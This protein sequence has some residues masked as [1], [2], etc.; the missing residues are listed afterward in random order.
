VARA[1]GA[2]E[3]WLEGRRHRIDGPAVEFPNGDYR[4]YRDDV[5]HRDGGPAV[6]CQGV[7]E[8]R[9]DG[10]LHRDDGPAYESG[11]EKLWLRKGKPHRLGGPAV[12][13]SSGRNE[14]WIEGKRAVA[15]FLENW[16]AISGAIHFA[17]V[18]K[19]VEN[20]NVYEEAAVKS[21][22][23]IGFHSLLA[24]L[25]KSGVSTWDD[26]ARAA[27][28]GLRNM[29]RP[30]TVVHSFN[31]MTLRCLGLG[32]EIAAGN[33]AG[34]PEGVRAELLGLLDRLLDDASP[35]LVADP[36]HGIEKP[37]PRRD[38]KGAVRVMLTQGKMRTRIREDVGSP[39]AEFAHGW[40]QGGARGRRVYASGTV[41]LDR[42]DAAEA[43][44]FATLA[45]P[46]GGAFDLRRIDGATFRPVF[47]PGGWT[48]A[49]EDEFRAAAADGGAWRDNP[50]LE[51]PKGTNCALGVRDVAMAP[52]KT[53]EGDNAAQA[54]SETACLARAGRLVVVDGVVHRR[55]AEPVLEIVATE[56]KPDEA[57]AGSLTR[58]QLAWRLGSDLSMTD[59]Q[60]TFRLGTDRVR[61]TGRKPGF[62]AVSAV[63][64]EHAQ[65]L[66]FPP[67]GHQRAAKI[68]ALWEDEPQGGLRGW[69]EED[70]LP[71]AVIVDG[72]APG[73]VAWLAATETDSLASTLDAIAKRAE[74][75][76]IILDADD[77]GMGREDLRDVVARATSEIES[78]DPNGLSDVASVLAKMA[79]QIDAGQV[80]TFPFGLKASG[81]L[82]ALLATTADSLRE[83][84]AL[85]AAD[86][87]EILSGFGMD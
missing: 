23:S 82:S 74:D 60:E 43:P 78:G 79:E 4:W 22:F 42:V 20:P 24:A 48:P 52:K 83:L 59:R 53:R 21:A 80:A 62:F 71:G 50:L 2:T 35:P 27:V 7:T 30:D 86:D 33:A 32:A 69:A 29:D 9:R 56:I 44:V 34:L 70:D 5:P 87:H 41:A 57:R 55:T 66:T 1:G 76:A 68:L 16:R 26:A 61:T 73:P 45:T 19:E 77:E 31:S 6:S 8:Y 15:P 3:W 39:T 28:A 13:R 64:D 10:R 12:E 54:D 25:E 38:F 75:C 72:Q 40:V 17:A 81:L 18:R 84:A 67:G 46:G 49:T 47:S 51:R 14:N 58:H 85:D 36:R 37:V 63:A 65:D 11:K